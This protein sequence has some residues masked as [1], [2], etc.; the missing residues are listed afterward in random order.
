MNLRVRL[1]LMSS[2]ILSIACVILTLAVNLSADKAITPAI[3]IIPSISEY[4]TEWNTLVPA[5]L[6][7]TT[8]YE[9][10]RI[11]SI[12]AMIFVVLMGTLSTYFLAGQTLKPLKQLTQEIK[13]K[14][15]N[16][17][18]EKITIPAIHDEIYE[19]ST[20][21]HEMSC[22]L[23]R[24]FQLQEQFSADAAHELRTPL[25]VMMAKLEV[26][27]LANEIENSALKNMIDEM[28]VQLERLSN[29]TNDLLWFSK[30]LPL[31]RNNE[32]DL[33]LLLSDLADE[34]QDKAQEKHIQIRV[35]K[36][37]L[38]TRGDDA[39]LER[40]FYNLLENAIKYSEEQSIIIVTLEQKDNQ[41]IV[42][43]IDTGEGISDAEKQ[44]VFQP[45]YRIDQ[46]RSRI[47]GGNGLGLAICKKILDRH[48]ASIEIK[49]NHPYGSIFELKFPS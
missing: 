5:A 14:T 24:S 48:L 30:E 34:L 47:I 2:M 11:E 15:I 18:D 42:Q 26:F 23:Q 20:A 41:A 49:D 31:K 44:L 32:L 46:S 43:I 21:F 36:K 8:Q 45:F 13:H 16:N 7:P 9:V 22:N 35:D 10:F 1:T 38:C 37:T 19:I 40:V 39:L 3:P 25:T 12:M 28:C 29:L 17:L 33:Y 6:V 4:Q 27:K